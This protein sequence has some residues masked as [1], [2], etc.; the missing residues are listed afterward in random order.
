ME[1]DGKFIEILSP[2]YGVNP[3]IV[4]L[5]R[6]SYSSIFFSMNLTFIYF[7]LTMIAIMT[8][9]KFGYISRLKSYYY[10]E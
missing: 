10:N 4:Y 3:I 7:C 6:E 1:I 5:Q 2:L 9:K 8:L